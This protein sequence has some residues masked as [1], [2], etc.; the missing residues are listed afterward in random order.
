MLASTRPRWTASTPQAATRTATIVSSSRHAQAGRAMEIR[1]RPSGLVRRAGRM[2]TG[3][4]SSGVGVTVCWYSGTLALQ[5]V[6]QD[7]DQAL[8]EGLRDAGG[9]LRRDRDGDE[10]AEDD[11]RTFQGGSL[12]SCGWGRGASTPQRLRAPPRSWWPTRQLG[13]APWRPA[14][15]A[16]PGTR[17]RCGRP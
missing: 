6:T 2:V 8:G 12:L 10:D 15:S 7:R 11:E 16:R 1:K 5:Q 13:L 17:R 14:R 4:R 3:G 9:G